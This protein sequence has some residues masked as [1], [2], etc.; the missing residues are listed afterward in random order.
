MLARDLISKLTPQEIEGAIP[1]PNGQTMPASG[2]LWNGVL[3]HQVHH[4]GQLSVYIRMM[5]GKVPS[6]YGP[7]GD[8]N[9]FA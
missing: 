6:I 2:L 3:M 8:E 4:R 1:L 5:G 9:P 7:S